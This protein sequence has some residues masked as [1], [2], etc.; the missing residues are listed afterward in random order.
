VDIAKSK[1]SAI[2]TEYL[3]FDI[4]HKGV[5]PQE[6]KI[7]TIMNNSMNVC[8]VRS[9]LRAINHC[10]QM[11]PYRFNVATDLSAPTKKG[12]KFKWTANC[13]AAFDTLKL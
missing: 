11:I 2:E 6:N 10:K 8:Q 13:R 12:A 5:K 4:S 3:G 1:F 7:E 9:F